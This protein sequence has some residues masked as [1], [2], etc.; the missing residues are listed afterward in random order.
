LLVAA[1]GATA[2]ARFLTDVDSPDALGAARRRLRLRRRWRCCS[3][4]S[5]EGSCT[6]VR[7]AAAAPLLLLVAPGAIAS[8]SRALEG[9]GGSISSS[10]RAVMKVASAF[11]S[12]LTLLPTMMPPSM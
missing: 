12:H 9:P 8:S 10:F 4:S 1:T 6:A 7:A 11:R 3:S 5:A 2:G